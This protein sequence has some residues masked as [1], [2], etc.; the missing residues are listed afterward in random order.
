MNIASRKFVYIFVRAKRSLRCPDA[1][2]FFSF[3]RI[4]GNIWSSEY[5]DRNARVDFEAIIRCRFF[6]DEHNKH[7]RMQY[8]S[9]AKEKREKKKRDEEVASGW[10]EAKKTVEEEDEGWKLAHSRFDELACGFWRHRWMIVV[11]LWWVFSVDIWS[12]LSEMIL[13]FI[14]DFDYRSMRD[15]K[16]DPSDQLDRSKKTSTRMSL[17]FVVPVPVDVDWRQSHRWKSVCL[18]FYLIDRRIRHWSIDV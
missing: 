12:P 14:S 2:Q 7:D 11:R 18:F 16:I 3:V 15:S 8:G 6:P 1:R 13:L 4:S 5:S 10:I 9:E 17:L